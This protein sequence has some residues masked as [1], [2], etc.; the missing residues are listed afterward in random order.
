MS[1]FAAFMKKNKAVKPN[2][3]Y[4]ATKSLTDEEGNP[5]EWEIRAITT[6]E[7]NSIR[8]SCTREVPVPGKFGVYRQKVDRD[9]IDK[10]TAAA[11]VYPNLYDEEL[12][13]SYGVSTPEDL[14]KEMVD[15]PAEYTELVRFVQE[16]S[17]YDVGMPDIVEEAKN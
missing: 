7:S 4:A 17:G 13:D 12:Q 10:I 16:Y 2:T 3:H 11:I 8:E 5:L 6:R 15:N 1:N 14:L 9:Y